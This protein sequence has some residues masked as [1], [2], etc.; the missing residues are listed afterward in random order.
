ME[1]NNKSYLLIFSIFLCVSILHFVFVPEKNNSYSI[2]FILVLGLG[3]LILIMKIPK[4][5]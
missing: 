4:S 3:I 1:R 2:P 5:K